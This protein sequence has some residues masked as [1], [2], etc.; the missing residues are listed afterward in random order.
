MADKNEA[1][2]CEKKRS[3]DLSRVRNK[4]RRSSLYKQ[5]KHNKNKEK[6]ERK[7]KRKREEEA[8]GD[9]VRIEVFIEPI[10][11]VYIYNYNL[12]VSARDV[13]FISIYQFSQLSDC[14]C[15]SC[16]LRV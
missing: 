10:I 2:S 1:N 13:S 16:V 4:V 3:I 15:V 9:E 8:L 6:R 14:R 5:E 7:K 11:E 12:T